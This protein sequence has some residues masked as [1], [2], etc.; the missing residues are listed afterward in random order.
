MRTIRKL[1]LSRAVTFAILIASAMGITGSSIAEAAV[2]KYCGQ[3]KV[4]DQ[5]G[6]ASPQDVAYDNTLQRCVV[7]IAPS[8][9]DRSYDVTQL[10][11]FKLP[12]FVSSINVYGVAGGGSAAMD[13]TNWWNSYFQNF[14]TDYVQ[15]TDSGGGGGGGAGFS[16][17]NLSVNSVYRFKMNAGLAGMLDESFTVYGGRDTRQG[18]FGSDGG[19]T[20]FGYSTDGSTTFTTI[21][22]GGGKAPATLA[23]NGGAAGTV[24]GTTSG[25]NTSNGNAGLSR[26]SNNGSAYGGFYISE[27]GGGTLGQGGGAAVYGGW[28]TGKGSGL[29]SGAAAAYVDSG[30]SIY[31]DIPCMMTQYRGKCDGNPGAIKL[32][33]AAVDYVPAYL[34]YSPSLNA[35]NPKVGEAL[36]V[37]SFVSVGSDVT[38]APTIAYAWYRCSG[39]VAYNSDSNAQA[40]GC[41]LISGATSG[42]YTPALADL[43]YRIQAKVT[44]ANSGLFSGTAT[45]S[46][47][48]VSYFTET[49]GDYVITTPSAPTASTTPTSKTPTS[50]KVTLTP[51]TS[52]GS[53]YSFSVVNSSDGATVGTAIYDGST[54]LNISGLTPSTAYS[55]KVKQT[56]TAGTSAGSTATLAFTTPV[57]VTNNGTPTFVVDPR[58]GKTASYTRIASWLG[59][60]TPT[61]THNW[62][63]CNAAQTA[64]YQSEGSVSTLVSGCTSTGTANSATLYISATYMGKYLT[65][66]ETAVDSFSTSYYRSASSTI[67]TGAMDAPVDVVA[68]PLY[69]YRVNVT[70][71]LPAFTGSSSQQ[72]ARKGEYSSDGGVTWISNGESADSVKSVLFNS[73]AGGTTYQLR[74]AIKNSSGTYSAWATTTVTT[75]RQLSVATYPTLSGGGTIGN[76]VSINPGSYVS[77]GTVS[78]GNIAWYG[79][80]TEKSGSYSGATGVS[81]CVA[82]SSSFNN[83]SSITPTGSS[84]NTYYYVFASIWVGDTTGSSGYVKTATVLFT[85]VPDPPTSVSG[86]ATSPTA[87]SVSFTAPVYSGAAAVTS[88]KY[89]VA[90]G[91]SFSSWSTPAF[92]N[93]GSATTFNITTGLAGGGTYKVRIYANN[94]SGISVASADSS[95]VTMPAVPSI[96]GVPTIS[97]I[98]AVGSTLTASTSPITVSGD[99][100]PSLTYSW[101]AC[102][103]TTDAGTLT[104]SCAAITN[105]T[106][107]TLAV[108]VNQSMKYLVFRVVATNTYGSAIAKSAVTVQV[109]GVPGAPVGVSVS[110]SSTSALLVSYTLPTD[111]GGGALTR[112]EYQYAASPYSSW[113]SFTAA[114]NMSGSL[115]ISGLSSNTSYQVRLRAVNAIGDG[116]AS[117]AST[118][119]TTLGAPVVAIAPSISGVAFVG[120]TV[121]AT[122]PAGMFTGNATPTVSARAWYACP[123]SKLAGDS[124]SSCSVISGATSTTYTLASAQL[125]SYV[126]FTATGENASGAAMASSASTA[127]VATVAAAPSITSVTLNGSGAVSVVISAG[128][129][130]YSAITG[131][132]YELNTSGT[133]VQTGSTATT[134]SIGSLTNGTAYS[135]KVRAINA[136]GN[137]SA[138]TASTFTPLAAA[139]GGSAT[140]GS[141]VLNLSWSAVTGATSYSVSFST[142]A[143]S[144]Y[145]TATGACAATSSTSCVLTGLTVGNAYYFKITA[146]NANGSAPISIAFGPT[147][148]LQIASISGTPTLSGSF[149]IG[150]TL[151]ADESGLTIAGH[152]TP[153]VTRVWFACGS[154][155]D[156]STL[157][158]SCAAISGATST[159]FIATSAES[160]K[161]LVYR[162]TATNSLGSESVRSATSAMIAGVPGAVTT[163][164][165]TATSTTSVTVSYTVPVDDGGSALTS[166]QYKYA[167]SPFSS[168]S[169]WTTASISTSSFVISGL[170]ANT[171]YQVIMRAVNA[172]G[173]GVDS[174]ASA[175]VTTLGGPSVVSAPTLSGT[176]TVGQTITAT[177]AAGMFAGTPT[178]TIS[179]RKWFACPSSRIA[180]ASLSGCTLIAGATST[181]L[182]LGVSQLGTYVVYSAT[183]QNSTATAD[184][185]SG[186]TAI[187][188]SAPTAPSITSSALNGS[189]S[190]AVTVL[191]GSANYSAI[192]DIQYEINASGTWISTGA[193]NTTFT[194]SSLVNGTSSAIRVRSVNTVGSS[195]AS[196]AVNVTPLAAVTGGSATRGDSQLALTWTPVAGASSYVVS[197][198]TLIGSGYQVSTGACASPTGASCLLTGLTN[199]N[200]YYFKV[201]AENA[202]GSS[203]VSASF[204]PNTPLSQNSN[205]SAMMVRA[206][207]SSGS[208][209]IGAN[210][211]PSF[212]G[213]IKNYSVE[214]A[215]GNQFVTVTATQGIAGQVLKVNGTTVTSGS[216]SSDLS[217]GYGTNTF[218]IQVQSPDRVADSASTAI[219]NYVVTVTRLNPDLSAFTG[220]ATSNTAASPVTSTFAN[221]GI[222]GVSNNN[223]SA[224]NS[225]I[226][227]LPA[228]SVD[229]PA[230]LQQIVDS[231]VSVLAQ[232]GGG[233]PSTSPSANDY[234]AIG[235]V[236]AQNFSAA[237]V[238]Y[239]NA[240]V[241]SLPVASAAQVSNL[242][243]VAQAIANLYSVAA[244]S[245]A[246]PITVSQLVALGITG[247][248]SANLADVVAA[249]AATADDGS[250][251]NTLAEVQA[252]VDSV[253]AASVNSIVSATTGQSPTL[254]TQSAFA[255]AGVSGVTSSNLTALNAILAALPSGSKDSTVEIQAVVNSL[256]LVLAQS[257]RVSVAGLSPSAST[258]A[259]I[260]ATAAASLSTSGISLLNNLLTL[261]PTTAFDTPAELNALAAAVSLIQTSVS[262]ATISDFSALGLTGVTAANLSTVRSLVAAE[263]I[264]AKDS[265][266]DLQ[267]LIDRAATAEAATNFANTSGATVIAPTV[268]DFIALGVVGV[269][270]SNISTLNAAI[271]AAAAA[272]NPIGSWVATPSAIQTLLD[273]VASVPIATLSGYS[274]TGY[275]PALADFQAVGVVGLKSN[276]LV[277]VNSYIAA[278]PQSA[279]DSTAEIQ[280][281]VTS[282]SNLVSAIT[283]GSTSRISVASLEAL[284][285]SGVTSDNVA[286]ISKAILAAGITGVDTLAELQAVV[287]AAV[288]AVSASVSEI[289][290]YSANPATAPAI[291]TYAAA[292][293]VGVSASNKDLV[294]SALATANPAPVT[295]SEIQAIINEV[296]AAPVSQIANL[297]SPSAD[298]RVADFALAGVS[299]VTSVNRA[300][301]VALLATLP[302]AA[303]DSIAEIQATVDSFALVQS[304]ALGGANNSA[305][306]PKPT[307]TNFAAIGVDLGAMT[308]DAQAFELFLTVLAKQPASVVSSPVELIERANIVVS[309]LRIASGKQS[310][311]EILPAQFQA[312]GITGVTGANITAVLAE[313]ASGAE[314]IAGITAIETALAKYEIPVVVRVRENQPRIPESTPEPTPAPTTEPTPAPTPKPIIKIPAPAVISFAA[315]SSTLTPATKAAV[316]NQVAKLIKSNIKTVVVRAVVTL[317][318]NSS[319]AWSNQVLAAGKN[320]ASM[321]AAVVAKKI[322]A[323]R[324][325]VKVV[326]KVSTTTAENTR[327]VNI[328]GTK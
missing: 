252:L 255:S 211:G 277:A 308:S 77:D 176:A 54:Y 294:D 95:T 171:G 33:Y 94:T 243:V 221:I 233:N 31:E 194:I 269:S 84:F 157:T 261:K 155:L 300:A 326:V 37:A 22:A 225:A 61:V 182:T 316:E 147:T 103:N 11:N 206:K 177:E 201:L 158:G 111:I 131:Y 6:N 122:E 307:P 190:T 71:N 224:V 68:T 107:D 301:L 164:T 127:I 24:S 75:P 254:P 315:G 137:S 49:T 102:A 97:G 207:Q 65:V 165:P 288:D 15:T 76:T 139:V 96:S 275:A 287:T 265:L 16:R 274:G 317:P 87:M 78:T 302:S 187:I 310:A 200:S 23:S 12:A 112:I 9:T 212:T 53:T 132:A 286:A 234:V 126:V 166:V 292:G 80:P 321:V 42:T 245:V 90:A 219:S 263:S 14:D 62:Y 18:W 123:S 296:I 181:T 175:T 146:S 160:R 256:S 124:L 241:S 99:P 66:V 51:S 313:I 285:V 188:A 230:E 198:S 237:Q 151:T 267:L 251:I 118:A 130:N 192:T 271:R 35:S 218:T 168:W 20:V 312:I 119:V 172:I 46:N 92:T 322:N 297:A 50:A 73:L 129:S 86:S 235:A 311:T 290:S 156:A 34:D 141:A 178:P 143:G 162:I 113:S 105:E 180:G 120:Q 106:T 306:S 268:Q 19:N 205:L 153:T 4:Y 210:L 5:W 138:S 298:I 289:V 328:S 52:W 232:A 319:K 227:A 115:T 278:L 163:F 41:S 264:G 209:A 48:S 203:P 179:A 280:S 152:T 25:W 17:T 250:G 217:I 281:V 161:Y 304:I 26:S 28:P 100:A 273:S 63:Y 204:G 10:D 323:L 1:G 309:L 202:N 299:G 21:T 159:T 173:A 104:G 142:L 13:T 38:P 318:K 47:T 282:Y 295:L 231:Y 108:S 226:A 81:G 114:P 148:V 259:A 57:A 140:S 170:N 213:A 89:S 276:M 284:G 238:T 43:G 133:W 266:A 110:A 229:S 30:A 270:G 128:T 191:L 283:T 39:S 184:A 7:S 109:P 150:A 272:A 208:N 193:T 247:V 74:V 257:S 134:F 70:F 69:W 149:A 91:P 216:Q 240:V 223:I 88:Y 93:Q 2:V 154:A 136:A 101:Y 258:Y 59:N 293:L 196:S 253:K 85:T 58:Q 186:S 36:D 305:Q 167:T 27:L 246:T 236:A 215:A 3:I 324:S 55:L 116:A 40:A 242:Q 199:G 314:G 125:G 83:L 144:G 244:G 79:C 260:G 279:T 239:L 327:V 72:T 183:G 117:I 185:S 44:L 82:L 197:Y 45:T 249:L 291:G 67:V 195:S 220:F 214:V 29:G 325:S 228:A 32:T 145:A 222:T 262:A 248:T 8:S 121:T 320:R 174:S 135:L 56:N 189:G 98:V 60:S 169:S 64:A 303:R